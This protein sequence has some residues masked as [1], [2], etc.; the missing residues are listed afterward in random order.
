MVV[1]QQG[2]EYQLPEHTNKKWGHNKLVSMN[3]KIPKSL[4]FGPTK[5]QK[6]EWLSNMNG[7]PKFMIKV[8]EKALS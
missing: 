7:D 2:T 4:E 6:N 8:H 5:K 3:R 1:H